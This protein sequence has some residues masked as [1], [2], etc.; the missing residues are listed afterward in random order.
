MDEVE[1][2]K[3]TGR[4][5]GNKRKKC[6]GGSDGPC[7][8]GENASCAVE[9]GNREGHRVLLLGR[10]IEQLK[11][12]RSAHDERAADVVRLALQQQLLDA[13]SSPTSLSGVG[14]QPGKSSSEPASQL[15]PPSSSAAPAKNVLPMA[16]G[17][18]QQ[19][20]AGTTP[21]MMLMPVW[22]PAG[23]TALA[24][25]VVPMSAEMMG[26]FGSSKPPQPPP[27]PHDHD[28]HDHGV[29]PSGKEPDSCDCG[30]CSSTHTKD[31]AMV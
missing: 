13:S 27:A 6:G 1:I 5:G 31:I 23:C 7:C 16:M 25:Q 29:C 10:A 8:E 11:A 14:S 12:L 30:P 9:S 17:Q 18:L 4:S 19:G 3:S 20:P 22:V 24:P 2:P 21:M 28:D 15:R 26:F